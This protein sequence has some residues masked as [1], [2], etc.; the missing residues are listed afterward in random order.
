MEFRSK[1]RLKRS[2]K[3]SLKTFWILFDELINQRGGY[4][5]VTVQQ[6]GEIRDQVMKEFGL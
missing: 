4:K 1:R 5:R 3:F 2:G 6:V